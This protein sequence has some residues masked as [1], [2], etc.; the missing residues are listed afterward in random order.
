MSSADIATDQ[1]A[2]DQL[3]K[4]RIAFPMR[5]RPWRNVAEQGTFGESIH[6]VAR[7][8]TQGGGGERLHNRLVLILLHGRIEIR[9]RYT[10]GSVVSSLGAR[11]KPIAF[12]SCPPNDMQFRHVAS[13][14]PR[15]TPRGLDAL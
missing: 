9:R 14:T 4:G 2:Y 6:D 1:T 15:I 8:N 12:G 5:C 7:Q 11:A 10:S 13:S 3:N